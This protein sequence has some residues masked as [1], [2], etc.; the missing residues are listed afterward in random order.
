[1]N[2][3]LQELKIT[4]SVIELYAY[5]INACTVTETVLKSQLAIALGGV[6]EEVTV[7]RYT[8]W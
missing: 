2:R 1:M 6:D 4:G 3:Y 5:D 7:K 8:S